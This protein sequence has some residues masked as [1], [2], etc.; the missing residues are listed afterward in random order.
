MGIEDYAHSKNKCC[1]CDS[2]NV[3]E[4]RTVLQI[5]IASVFS[6]VV[7]FRSRLYTFSENKTCRRA[8]SALHCIST[9]KRN[10]ETDC[11]RSC[12]RL[13]SRFFVGLKP[14][15]TRCV[16]VQ[17]DKAA[18]DQEEFMHELSALKAIHDA[19]GHPNIAGER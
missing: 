16:R 4:K 14:K 8:V 3:W 12:V 5:P 2:I 18:M 13:R 6:N 10:I 7:L 19:G 15:P 11:R 17:V 9:S 1:T